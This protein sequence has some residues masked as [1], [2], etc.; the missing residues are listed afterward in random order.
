MPERKVA[1]KPGA[2]DR[3]DCWDPA[4]RDSFRDLAN[5]KDTPD[6]ERKQTG[7]CGEAQADGVPCVTPKTL[8]ELCGR[9]H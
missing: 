9:A 8:C 6:T 2:D 3:L 5:A 4:K 7:L 1:M